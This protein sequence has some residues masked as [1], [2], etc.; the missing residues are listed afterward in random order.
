MLYDARM[1][2][3]EVIHTVMNA[4][5]S[6]QYFVEAGIPARAGDTITAAQVETV[7]TRLTRRMH[8]L[9]GWL[10]S[11]D[12]MVVPEEVYISIRG[13]DSDGGLLVIN[14]SKPTFSDSYRVAEQP[15][16]TITTHGDYTFDLRRTVS[17]SDTLTT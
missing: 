9:L 12:P 6:Y 4:A 16:P 14:H 2:S 5:D 11:D 3:P 8:R 15:P 17:S 10:D 13:V 1:A 7:L